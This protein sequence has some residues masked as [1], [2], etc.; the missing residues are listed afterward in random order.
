M[1]ALAAAMLLTVTSPLLAV[2]TAD[3]AHATS[4]APLSVEQMTDASTY[5]VRG[6]V[7]RVW[8]E[9]DAGGVVW[10]RA[11][12][13][14]A[15]TFKGPDAPETLI[16]DAMGGEA[17][18]VALWMD[19]M[20]RFSEGEDILVFLDSI[21]HDTRLTPVGAF[22]GKYTVRRPPHETRSIA[23][24]YEVRP[25]VRYDARFLPVP[26]REQWVFVDD[27][28]AQVHRRVVAGWDGAPIPG[29][30]PAKLQTIN[31]ADRRAH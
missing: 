8:T 16:V 4:I 26:P 14:V 2:I 11:E 17:G 30:T 7:T 24:P 10:T 31:A 12:L 21:R 15:R 29:L 25:A 22:T 18:G 9:L 3:A 1:R 27:L 23:V 5:V 13:A 19:G 6:R 20:P 28:E